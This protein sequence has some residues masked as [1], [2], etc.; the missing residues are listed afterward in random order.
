MLTAAG[1][2]VPLVFEM[3]ERRISEHMMQA[4]F[5]PTLT[6]VWFSWSPEFEFPGSAVHPFPS[7]L[8]LNV[9][10]S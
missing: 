7:T 4:V 2:I 1:N 10:A 8:H 9:V 5:R 3:L 6:I